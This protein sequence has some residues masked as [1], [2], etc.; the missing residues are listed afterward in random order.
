MTEE[1]AVGALKAARDAGHIDAEDAYVSDIAGTAN[2]MAGFLKMKGTFSFNEKS[3]KY[4]IYA[5]D[6]F[7]YRHFVN[8]L[9]NEIGSQYFDVW[10]GK[11]KS[12]SKTT[13][14]QEGEMITEN[15]INLQEGRP[16]RGLDYKIPYKNWAMIDHASVQE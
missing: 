10:D 2:A 14:N 3:P 8:A 11:T 16:I 5:I 9:I 4:M 1:Q 7:T 12:Y 15:L 6:K 13:T